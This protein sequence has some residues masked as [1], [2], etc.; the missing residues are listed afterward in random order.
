MEITITPEL[1]QTL[2]GPAVAALLPAILRRIKSW[3]AAGRNDHTSVAVSVNHSL[4]R[5]DVVVRV[6]SDLNKSSRDLCS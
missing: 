1:F 4:A 2:I 5:M 6:S 3:R